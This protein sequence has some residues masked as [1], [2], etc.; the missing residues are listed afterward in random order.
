MTANNCMKDLPNGVKCTGAHSRLLC[1]SGNAY[2]FAA[3]AGQKV[4]PEVSKVCDVDLED[5][6]E[7]A[8]TVCFFQNIPVQGHD[9]QARTFFDNGSN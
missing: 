4:A 8:E 9:V 7:S 6:N 1:G 2:C 3:K 5:V